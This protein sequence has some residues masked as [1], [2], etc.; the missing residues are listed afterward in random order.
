MT[1]VALIRPTFVSFDVAA[2]QR[3]AAVRAILRRRGDW[4]QRSLWVALPT[5]AADVEPLFA[6]LEARLGVAD[7]MIVHRPC[8]RCLALVDLRPGWRMD[9]DSA[10]PSLSVR[11]R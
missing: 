2:D 7:R 5:R 3:R 11:T 9:L 1:V 4:V 6:Q 8:L 10:G